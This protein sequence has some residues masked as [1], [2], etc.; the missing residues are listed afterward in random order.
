MLA[1]SLRGQRGACHAQLPLVLG[2]QKTMRF[3]LVVQARHQQ[4]YDSGKKQDTEKRM[5][6]GLGA[7]LRVSLINIHI[8][9]ISLSRN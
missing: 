7:V 3:S 4:Y 1:S 8:F 6:S 5:Y 2:G 9:F